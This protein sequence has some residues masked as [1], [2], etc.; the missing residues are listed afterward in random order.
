ME[1]LKVNVTTD[2]NQ[3]SLFKSNRNVNLAHVKAIEMSI[4]SKG[5]LCKPIIVNEKMQV[6]EGQHRLEACKNINS[7]IYYIIVKD[8]NVRE[9]YAFNTSHKNWGGV[10]Y[11]ESYAKMGVESYIKLQKFMHKHPT[12]SFFVCK[13][14]CANKNNNGRHTYSENTRIYRKD[15]FVDGKWET[16]D[17]ELAEEYAQRLYIIGE[18][19]KLATNASFV[20]CMIYLFNKSIFDFEVFIRKLKLQPLALKKCANGKQYTELIEEIYNYKSKNKIS[21]K[22]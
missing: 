10:E 22:Y 14:L 15:D 6:V 12:F 19:F 5:L 2:L 1:N 11:L 7:P 4:A 16:A 13:S 3:F 21:L 8:Y 20:T 9:I 17:M 18:Y